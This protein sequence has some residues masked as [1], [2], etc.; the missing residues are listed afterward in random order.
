MIF[1]FVEYKDG[2]YIIL[3]K[4]KNKEA[5]EPYFV[6]I[7]YIY[8]YYCFRN[9]GYFKSRKK[10]VYETEIFKKKKSIQPSNKRI[11]NKGEEKVTF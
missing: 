11:S 6:I 5:F 1:S 9:C 3:L 7:I 4:K 8:K 10:L 2:R